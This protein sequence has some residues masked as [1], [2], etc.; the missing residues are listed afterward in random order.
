MKK[1]NS[2]RAQGEKSLSYET[3]REASE[4]ACLPIPKPRLHAEYAGRW[5]HIPKTL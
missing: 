2:V 1:A 5:T 4:E 3:R